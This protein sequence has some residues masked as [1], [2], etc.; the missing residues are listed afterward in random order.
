VLEKNTMT[1]NCTHGCCPPKAT[2]FKE[3]TTIVLV[4]I[5]SLEAVDER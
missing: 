3:M 4:V 5:I 1:M 2:K